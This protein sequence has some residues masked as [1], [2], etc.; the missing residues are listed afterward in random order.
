MF[1]IDWIDRR[2]WEPEVGGQPVVDRQSLWILESVS[3]VGRLH[4]HLL[5]RNR[6]TVFRM[7][8]PF[9]WDWCFP[10]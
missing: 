7:L 9:R 3:G 4:H 1:P 8:L 10:L 6:R 5:A 2:S